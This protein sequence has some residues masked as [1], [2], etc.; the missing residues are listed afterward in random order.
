LVKPP[1]DA[2]KRKSPLYA[3][4][5]G[6]FC[7]AAFDAQHCDGSAAATL[8]NSDGTELDAAMTLPR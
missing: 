3:H 5:C 6:I 4:I 2:G 8:G 7:W 1:R